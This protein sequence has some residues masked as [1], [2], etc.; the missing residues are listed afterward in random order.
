MP[1]LSAPDLALEI[2]SGTHLAAWGTPASRTAGGPWTGVLPPSLVPTDPGM[3]RVILSRNDGG[4]L[5]RFY[6][7]AVRLLP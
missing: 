4:A 7:L 6:R 5:K 2:Q 3:E 1:T